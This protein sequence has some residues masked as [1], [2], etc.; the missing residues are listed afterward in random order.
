MNRKNLYWILWS[1]YS[2]KIIVV[3]LWTQY[4][5]VLNHSPATVQFIHPFILFV[6][7]VEFIALISLYSKIDKS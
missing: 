4:I 2:T 1:L 5:A 7:A 6:L 3:I